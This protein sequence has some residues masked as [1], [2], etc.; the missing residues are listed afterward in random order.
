[1]VTNLSQTIKGLFFAIPC[2]AISCNSNS[3]VPP[4]AEPV[5]VEAIRPSVV[6]FCGDCHATPRPEQF[7]KSAWSDEVDQGY[8]FYYQSG[9]TDLV[10]P[11]KRQI[12]E[13]YRQ[14][15]PE[16]L[17]VPNAPSPDGKLSFVRT[18]VDVRP[19]LSE[20][21]KIELPEVS[22]INWVAG[23]FHGGNEHQQLLV[24]DMRL[25]AFAECS[26]AL[27][28]TNVHTWIDVGNPAHAELTD[29]DND[30]KPDIVLAD[31][32]SPLPED[33]DRGRV[34]WL[35]RPEKRENWRVTELAT[36]L[37]RVADVRPGDFDGDGDIDLV[38]AE[39]GWLKTGRILLLVNQG[40]DLEVPRFDISILDTRHGA[41]HVPVIDLNGD[42]RLDFVALISQEHETIE[43]FIN[44]GDGSFHTE[45]LFTADDASF[46][47]SGI[48]LVDIDSDGDQ[49]VLYSNGDM[50]DSLYLKPTHAIHWI[51]N[52]GT[53]SWKSHLLAN[54]PGV[55][56]AIARDMD[57]DGDADIV[58]ASMIP[59]TA[60]NRNDSSLN[61]ASLL[62]VEQVSPGE[63]VTH[64]LE[65]NNCVHAAFEIA[66]FDNDGDIDLAVGDFRAGSG[67]FISIWW[68]EL[69]QPDR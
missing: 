4:R 7:P 67:S 10:I 34:L 54:M 13:F 55:M 19:Y 26:P 43:A 66:D 35:Q 51:E 68:N 52:S 23:I 63:F 27:L 53:G 62:W 57:N 17:A 30:G 41:I 20:S 11:P 5:D 37:G 15:A 8:D 36:G 6:A 49:D 24:C 16:K 69:V 25:G 60:F 50:L 38:V 18:R 1:M 3:T 14:L 61:L 59:A 56:R 33:H 22:H 45:I 46:G 12:V 28:G 31:L 29:L 2:L 39:F 40:G 47:S 42:G 48:Q 21:Q 64:S 65:S 32:G 9:R 58:A 44:Q